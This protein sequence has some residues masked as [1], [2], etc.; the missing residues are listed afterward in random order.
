MHIP[1]MKIH[2]FYPTDV[3]LVLPRT[4]DFL[5]PPTFSLESICPEQVGRTVTKTCLKVKFLVC[6]L[7]W[8]STKKQQWFWKK[9]R[10]LEM[11][12]NNLISVHVPRMDG[13]R[14]IFEAE[15]SHKSFM[16]QKSAICYAA[17]WPWING[18][19]VRL[20]PDMAERQGF[21]P[22]R[23]FR[24]YPPSKRAH[25]TTMRSLLNNTPRTSCSAFARL[26]G[27]HE[28]QSLLGF[29]IQLDICART[30]FLILEPFA[31]LF[32]GLKF[33]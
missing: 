1:E 28:T 2:H 25:S 4:I 20:M 15:V 16:Q 7:L 31:R 30:F 29:P 21:E 10:W 8:F 32:G 24:P 13:T 33:F 6:P 23:A 5:V 18:F 17:R 14:T 12:L 11:T 26:F 27:A 9:S 19:T 22:W 3:I